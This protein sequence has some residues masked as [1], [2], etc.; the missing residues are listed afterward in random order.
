[1]VRVGCYSQQAFQIYK[2]IKFGVGMKPQFTCFTN[3]LLIGIT[4]PLINNT[5]KIF[6]KPKGDAM[7]SLHFS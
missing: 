4:M 5:N 2:I 6:Q 7:L 1:M 3:A